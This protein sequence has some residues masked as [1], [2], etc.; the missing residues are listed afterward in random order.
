M[1]KLLVVC[2]PTATG[3]TSLGLKMAQKFNGEIISADSRQV[4]AG[5]DI[6][7][8][9]DLPPAVTSQ[10]SN[11]SWQG[12]FLK[13]YEI[14]KIKVWGYDLVNPDQDFNVSFWNECAKILISDIRSR[15]KLPIIVGGTGLY[16]KSLTVSMPDIDI[17]QNPDLRLSLKDKSADDLLDY[18]SLL[19]FARAQQLNSSDRK[20]PRRLIRAIE[21]SQFKLSGGVS[22]S[23]P[24]APTDVFSICLTAPIQFLKSRIDQKISQRIAAGAFFEAQNLLATFPPDLSSLS[25]CGYRA[26]CNPDWESSWSRSEHQYLKRQLTWFKKQPNLFWCD[27]STDSW[28]DLCFSAVTNWYNN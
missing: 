8:G 18:L 3:K 12:R 28:S 11:L 21:I 27:I 2:G 16:L 25:A 5:M 26:F 14:E 15:G 23:Q 10:V 17:P 19:D 20:N 22:A 6:V 9:K 13:Y 4:Y 24:K 1:S 7:T